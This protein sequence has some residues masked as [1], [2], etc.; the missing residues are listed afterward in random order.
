[1]RSRRVEE[2][3]AD[4]LAIWEERRDIT[5]EELR[6]ALAD[7]GMAVSVAGLHRFFVRRGLTRKKRQAMR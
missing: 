6:L 1:M 5:L 3:A 2:R 7:K 4:I